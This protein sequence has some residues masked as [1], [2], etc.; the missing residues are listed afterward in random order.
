MCPLLRSWLD[1][2]NE[3]KRLTN[4]RFSD[5]IFFS[6]SSF[7]Q[8]PLHRR[9]H[10]SSIAKPLI[11]F[12]NSVPIEPGSFYRAFMEYEESSIRMNS[13]YKGEDGKEEETVDDVTFK[14][15][16]CPYIVSTDVR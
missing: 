2:G 9:R 11:K 12:N 10:G 3:F 6:N 5:S 7:R 16:D 1:S 14:F 15:E 8:L 4:K 13:C